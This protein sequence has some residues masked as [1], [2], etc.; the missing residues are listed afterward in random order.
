MS[1]IV[2]YGVVASLGITAAIAVITATGTVAVGSYTYTLTP[3]YT[4]GRIT[5]V[6]GGTCAAAGVC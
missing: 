3:T 1:T 4:N 2:A 6:G 5:W